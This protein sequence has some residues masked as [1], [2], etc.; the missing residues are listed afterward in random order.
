MDTFKEIALRAMYRHLI[1]NE[2]HEWFLE[3]PEAKR[4]RLR[5]HIDMSSKEPSPI[6][7]A[8]ILPVH[9]PMS[10]HRVSR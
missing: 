7:D 6:S 2:I 9:L 8:I 5:L 1:S 4:P 3:F 10:L